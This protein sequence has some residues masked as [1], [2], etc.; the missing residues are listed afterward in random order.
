MNIPTLTTERLTLRPFTMTDADRVSELLQ[1]PAIA[2][3]TLYIPYPYT[4][5]DA[6]MWIAMHPAA[7]G[8][9]RELIWAIWLR[10]GSNLIGTI[11]MEIN[12]QHCRGALGY[13]LGVPWWGQGIMSE[14]ANAVVDYGFDA[15][16]LHRIEATRMPDNAGSARVMEK[17]GLAYE[18]TLR[19][20]YL[21]NGQFLDAAIH[22]RV[23]EASSPSRKHHTP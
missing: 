5:E 16:D 14:A 12:A 10:E 23:R 2:E 11:S 3:T 18:C 19:G 21:K 9:G 6:A 13:W 8:T 22:A 7:A 1:D 17:A 15:L 20:Y 4:R